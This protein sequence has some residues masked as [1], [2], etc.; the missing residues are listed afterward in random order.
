MQRIGL[1]ILLAVSI[2]MQMLD[3]TIL[4]T[5]LPAVA[6]D[7]QQ[8]VLTMQ[9]AVVSYVLTVAVCIPLTGYLSDRFGTRRMFVLAMTLFG[10]GSL[11]CA[12]ASSLSA[13]VVARVVQG[14]GGALLTPVARLVLMRAFEGPALLK[15]LNY[16]VLP[17]LM[18]P[19][20]GPLVGGYLVEQASWHWIFLMNLPFVVLALGLSLKIMPN[21]T[22]SDTHLDLF[23]VLLLGVAAFLLTLGVEL[24][25][26]PFSLWLSAALVGSGVFLFGG[27]W[28]HARQEPR[29]IYPPDLWQVRTYRIG[30]NSNLL[31]RMG[32]A[33][34]PLLLPL[35]F[36][37]VFGYRPLEAAW[38]LVPMALAAMLAKPLLVPL[39]QRWGYRRVLL[40]N[41]ACIGLLLAG[42]A[43]FSLQTP[44]WYIGVHLFFLGM[45]NSIQFTAI[46]TLTVADLR[47]YQKSS[48]NS[49][50]AMNQ[51]LAMG[52]GT[53]LGAML[54][55]FNE[56]LFMAQAAALYR[57]FQLT[58]VLLGLL[59]FVTGVLFK[60]LHARDGAQMAARAQ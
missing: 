2:F 25:A 17:A 7:F 52:L 57:G 11:L 10:L 37:V 47:T 19:L 58:F 60:Y 51:Q 14:L 34:I 1:P 22:R 33:S 35:L 9:S 44:K 27:Y 28:R 16:A 30:L 15:A 46:N 24:T 50:M 4:N 36:Q 55:R 54:V 49:L 43:L 59:T 12:L 13:L 32:V 40:W 21:Y 3:V 42:L 41:T 6:R 8:P 20:L 56:F 38:L 29:A 45:A 18:G 31:T 23:G 39:L 53:A 26:T 48:A 5:A